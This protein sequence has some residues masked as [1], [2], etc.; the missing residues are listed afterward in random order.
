MITYTKDLTITANGIPPVVRISQYSD[1]F[2]IVFYLKDTDGLLNIQ[3]GTTATVRGTKV[4]GNGY[5][6]NATIDIANK[7][8]TVSGHKQ[9]TAVAGE[10]VFEVV[11]WKG[12]K[13]LASTNF[14]LLVE[15]AAMDANTVPSETIIKEIGEEVDRYLDEHEIVI[16]RTLS[17]DGAAAESK[18]VGDNIRRIDGQIGTLGTRIT[19][20]EDDISYQSQRVDRTNKIKAPVIWEE[21]SGYPAVFDDGA[22]GMYV[23]DL[24]L[25]LTPSQDLNGYGYAWAGGNGKNLL[26]AKAGTVANLNG[27]GTVTINSDGSITVNGVQNSAF[28][29][30]GNLATGFIGTGAGQ[31]DG[32][33]HIPNGSYILTTGLT[34]QTRIVV[35]VYGT[36]QAIGT[37]DLHSITVVST[38]SVFTIDD[39]YAYNYIRLYVGTGTYNNVTFYPMIRRASE[40]DDTFAPYENICPINGAESVTVK[41]TG[42]NV[43]KSVGQTNTGKGVTATVNADG[44]VTLNGTATEDVIVIYNF[45]YDT[46]G[47]PSRQNI[48]KKCI[49]NGEYTVSLGTDNTNYAF[50]IYGS[51]NAGTGDVHQLF[52]GRN[53][54]LIIDDTYAYNW[55]RLYVANGA[56]SDNTVL[57]PMIRPASISDD[58]YEPYDELDT[59]VNFGQTI[60]GGTVNPILWHLQ[61]GDIVFDRK[62][63]S[64]GDLTWSKQ[65]GNIFKATPDNITGSSDYDMSDTFRRNGIYA[66][67][68]NGDF[69]LSVAGTLYVKMEGFDTAA[70]FKAAYA[71]AKFCAKLAHSEIGS[72]YPDLREITTAYLDN[73]ITAQ[74]DKGNVTNIKVTYPADTKTYID[75]AIAAASL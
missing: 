55:V 31:N 63:F 71:D 34:N 28:I 69:Y 22:D 36:N 8:V 42:K 17:Q 24:T 40:S 68:Q 1:D 52:S 48:A 16:D 43:L 23:K 74:P 75:K 58:T 20:T 66:N 73:V 39:T 5:S 7:T 38:E 54:S 6:A 49:P 19:N 50:Q 56:V 44:T 45:E 26:E 37:S 12:E 10:N 59:N 65:S 57:Y 13:E 15:P 32:V 62:V 46:G 70:G 3:S 25:T 18:T 21:A 30:I 60:Y 27:S 47:N 61:G 11:L 72:M 41:R 35:Q 67:L 64:V 14:V 33:K 4:D 2:G 9:M 51:N 53:G 29:P